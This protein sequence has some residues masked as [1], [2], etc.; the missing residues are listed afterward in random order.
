MTNKS[1]KSS[2]NNLGEFKVKPVLVET[3]NPYKSLLV[4]ICRYGHASPNPYSP[5]CY[6]CWK[7]GKKTALLEAKIK[8]VGKQKVQKQ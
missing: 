8:S 1:I 4:Y 6:Y 5:W 7:E 2:L 3:N